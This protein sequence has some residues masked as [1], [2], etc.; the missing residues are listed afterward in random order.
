MAAELVPRRT[1]KHP[2]VRF[3]RVVSP[4]LVFLQL[5]RF[6]G[7]SSSLSRGVASAQL[8]G[9]LLVQRPLRVELT[10]DGAWMNSW[11]R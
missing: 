2:G 3:E 4:S 11:L 6:R 5:A 7:H 1:R 10:G 9:I 8:D